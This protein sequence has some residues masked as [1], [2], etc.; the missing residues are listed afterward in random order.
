MDSTN[1]SGKPV[2]FDLYIDGARHPE[3]VF[4]PT[5]TGTVASPTAIPFGI[6]GN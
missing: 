4:Y 5:S 3:L 6:L 1:G 2:Y